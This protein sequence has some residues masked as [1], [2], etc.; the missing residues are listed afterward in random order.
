MC[1]KSLKNSAKFLSF[2]TLLVTAHL[3]LKSQVQANFT[4]DTTRGCGSVTVNFTS[5]SSG[6]IS[7]YLWDFGN[8]NSSTLQNPSATYSSAG[9]FDVSLTVS[10]ASGTQSDNLTQANFITVYQLPNADFTFSPN[11]GCS[12]ISINFTN[13][14]TAGSAPIVSN[15]WVFADGSQPFQGNNATHTYQ[16]PGNF[17]PSLEV[18]DQNGCRD[19]AVNDTVFVT[20][21]PVANF[22]T[23]N[24]RISCLAPYTVNFRSN[25]T[26]F[27]LSYL[28]DFGDGTSSTQQNPSHTYNSLGKYDV[29]L[30]VSDPNCSD[31]LLISDYIILENSLAKFSLNN[32]TLCAGEPF[33]P[34][35]SSQGAAI[36]SWNFGDGTTINSSQPTHTYQD[37][38][39]F[40]IRLSVSAGAACTDTYFDTVYVDKVVADFTVTQAFSCKFNEQVQFNFTGINA[41][42]L[43]WRIDSGQSNVAEYLGDSVLH[44]Q[45]FY[46]NIGDTIFFDD[47]LIAISPLGCRDTLVKDTNRIIQPIDV[48][49]GM[50]SLVINSLDT[51][52]FLSGCLPQTRSFT[53]STLGPGNINRW[54]WSFSATD[55][56]T[57]KTPPDM[58]FDTD[59][60]YPVKLTVWND[61][62]CTG[63]E[64]FNYLGGFKQTPRASFVNDSLCP[65]D[66]LFVVDESFDSTKI[67]YTGFILI[68]SDTGGV[69]TTEELFG[70]IN[71]T[72]TF[73]TTHYPS[74]GYHFLNVIVSHNG[75]DT[76]YASTDSIY[77]K[78]P[79]SDMV[80]I[81]PFCDSLNDLTPTVQFFGNL[82]DVDRFYWD[83]GDSSAI[84]STNENPRHTYTD[85]NTY[86]VYLTS[87]ND[88]NNCG[89][90]VDS[91]EVN[92]AP[93]KAPVIQPYL[94]NFCLYDTIFLE[95]DGP[96]VSYFEEYWEINGDTVAQSPDY[97]FI[98]D[99]TGN[100]E[101]KLHVIDALICTSTVV[102]NIYISDIKANFSSEVIDGCLPM[103]IRFQDSSYSDTAINS[104]YWRFGNGDTSIFEIDSTVYATA[105]KKDVFLRVENSL[106]CK[107]SILKKGYININNVSVNFS[108]SK[109]VICVGDSVLFRNQSSGQNVN[110]LWVF[111]EDS[112]F[113]NDQLV[114]Y[115]FTTADT[116]DIRLYG[117]NDN[118]CIVIENKP[119][120]LIVGA[121]PQA[122]FVADTLQSACY[123]LS[124]NFTDLSTGDV[125][126]WFWEFGDG[127]SSIFQNPFNRYTSLG[128]FD[129]SLKVVNEAG[130]ADSTIKTA[131][132]QT[133]GPA[134]E[135]QLSKD[136]ACI[137]EAITFNLIN[138]QNVDDFEWDF[139]DGTTSKDATTSHA[140]KRTGTVYFT[141]SLFDSLGYCRVNLRDSI[142]I[143]DISANFTVN[144]DT[145]CQPFQ[146]QFIATSAGASQLSWNFGDG[147]SSTDPIVNHTYHNAGLF[148]AELKVNSQL[149]CKDTAQK[150]ILVHP[151]PQARKHNDTTICLGDTLELWVKGG[152]TYDWNNE[153]FLARDSSS[154]TLA[155]PDTTTSFTIHVFNEFNCIDTA[156]IIVNVQAPPIPNP[157]NYSDSS[158]IIGEYIDLDATAGD[159]FQYS[160]L[161]SEGL[162]CPNC[163]IT[164]AQPLKNTSYVVS[165]SDQ[166]G[167]FT[168]KDTIFIEV[169][170]EYTLD[171]PNA[172]SPNGDG[173]NDIIYA[174]GWGLKELIAFKIYNRFGELIFES[175]DFDKGWDGTYKGKAQNM[176]TYVYTVEAETYSGQVLSKKGNITLLR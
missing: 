41:E 95:Y 154:S 21:S 176:E 151:K 63:T 11:G 109:S 44:N 136:S 153:Q 165:I 133:N 160:W 163:P 138:Q 55:S 132:I 57:L 161:P 31:T 54:Q 66:T 47:S 164:R 118:G 80:G 137:N 174:K 166:F 157:L 147:G 29:T 106:G 42:Q 90:F 129:V 1:E 134:A 171:V 84:D 59:T 53:D 75:C 148:T 38:G 150:D 94:D 146:A 101:I 123:P 22:N 144:E 130:C 155:F 86:T 49:I 17:V 9:S 2:L 15:E 51:L 112:L 48:R 70:R 115:T 91:F 65:N 96:G 135:I 126:Q 173:N 69:V 46:K 108:Q 100:Y 58:T 14:S 119:S 169:I 89:P 34:I 145:A 40:V 170:E 124:V 125:T 20:Q 122:D 52:T 45:Y 32:D 62:G 24:N 67:N 43:I 18:V 25:S 102:K 39:T 98:P 110:Y 158:I 111:G 113:S 76:S 105:G 79:R 64:M 156:K 97:N 83:F 168:I 107:D 142:H 85:T 104:W 12:P 28:W 167:C 172:F 8:G 5:T 60:A 19:F 35:D 82:Y 33:S 128:T 30:I 120:A 68:R 4:A 78:G 71:N 50:D 149:G 143:F 13:N 99:D 73:Y 131:Y 114:S 141:L 117:I 127:N 6:N 116:F 37:S 93:Y 10:N 81:N 88:G 140:F 61:L 121:Q 74:I 16:T 162:S 159:G 152:E 56:S 92:L 77:L 26:G 23:S 27:N 103:D 139:G 175:N 7:N 36:Y 87:Y 3:S 72:D